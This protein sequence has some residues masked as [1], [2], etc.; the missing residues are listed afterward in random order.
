MKCNDLLHRSAGYENEGF[1][2]IIQS[3]K[4]L[5]IIEKYDADQSSLKQNII[6]E[7]ERQNRIATWD[8]FKGV[9]SKNDNFT[10]AK[11]DWYEQ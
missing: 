7:D 3:L 8:K 1:L 2:Q 10:S 11:E 5:G 4:N 9:L 6:T